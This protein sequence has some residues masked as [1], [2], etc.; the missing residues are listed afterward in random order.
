MP[1]PSTQPASRKHQPQDAPGV[2]ADRDADAELAR[3]LGDAVG[4]HAVEPDRR[5]HQRQ[6]AE[7]RGDRRHQP[8]AQQ[9]AADV[10]LGGADVGHRRVADRAPRLSV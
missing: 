7:E 3:A 6:A 5:Q 10:V 8:F 1:A 9:R 4:E 2:R